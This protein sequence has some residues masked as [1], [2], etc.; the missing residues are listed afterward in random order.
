VLEFAFRPEPHGP[1]PIYQ[2]LAAYLRGLIDAGRV[3]PGE[4]FPATRELCD[5]LGLGRNTVARAYRVLVDAGVLVS[6][7][8]QGTFVASGRLRPIEGGSPPAADRPARGFAWEGLLANRVSRVVLPTGVGSLSRVAARYDFGGGCVDEESIPTAELKRVWSRALESSVA[9]LAR[10]G[11]PYG[12]APLREE[13]ALSLVARGISCDADD[14][15]ITDGVH[16]ALDLVARALID[17][18]DAVVVEQPGYFAATMTFRAYGARVVGVGV[19]D[20]GLQVEELARI[21]R[22][23]RAKLVYVTPSAQAPTGA[24]LSERRRAALLEV[25]D[26]YQLPVFEDDYDSELRFQSPPIAALKTRDEA[27]RVIYAGTFSKALFPGLRVGYVV[28]PRSLLGRL[29]TYRM[30]SD[31][32]TDGVAQAAVLELMLSGTLERHIRRQ[33]R[34]YTRRRNVLLEALENWMPAG[35]RFTRP[36]GGHA[37]WLTLPPEVDGVAL[38]AAA[39]AAGI[40]YPRGDFYSIDGR[41]SDCFALSFTNQTEAAIE[42]GV[43]ELAGLIATLQPRSRSRDAA[44]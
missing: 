9:L 2:Q 25:S 40:A 10:P 5:Q 30:L 7:V 38:H 28:A 11:S 29:A 14:V 15:L 19:D 32:S 16:Q 22:V 33:R 26:Q 13:I 17:P 44:G 21:L 39:Q 31:F 37:V 6:H 36:Q 24:I 23:R 8:G 35:T 12:L 43:A 20:E 27:G 18:G 3:I 1:T 41:F 4:R 42:A 34:L